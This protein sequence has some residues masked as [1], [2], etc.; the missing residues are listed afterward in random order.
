MA[1]NIGSLR[2]KFDGSEPFMSGGH[3]L[4]TTTG[5]SQHKRRLAKLP[6]WA[7]DDVIIKSIL[8]TAF[9]R[10]QTDDNQRARAGKWASIINYYFKMG[11]TQSKIADEMNLTEYNVNTTI[12]A[13]KRA[14]NGKN[15]KTGRPRGKRGRPKKNTALIETPNGDTLG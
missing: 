7:L 1:K 2:H 4:I 14:A 13:I 8:L 5:A 11:W 9:P 12:R 10:L 6:V 3:Q 15:S